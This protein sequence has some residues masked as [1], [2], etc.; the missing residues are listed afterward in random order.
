MDTS[1]AASL[2]YT[3][4]TYDITN[5]RIPKSKEVRYLLEVAIPSGGTAVDVDEGGVID[6]VFP[7]GY[8]LNSFC[9]NEKDSELQALTTGSF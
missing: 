4:N 9:E 5:T 2:T 3:V 1:L 7:P 6:F 8:T